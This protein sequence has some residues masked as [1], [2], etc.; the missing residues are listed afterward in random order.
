MTNMRHKSPDARRGRRQRYINAIEPF[1]TKYGC[2]AAEVFGVI[3]GIESKAVQLSYKVE[4]LNNENGKLQT[5]LTA[6]NNERIAH[7]AEMKL[8]KDQ[9][10]SQSQMISDLTEHNNQLTDENTQLTQQL[11]FTK[12]ELATSLASEV[13]PTPA[14]KSKKS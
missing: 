11:A 3:S 5:E 12:G 14:K 8:L 2:T 4:H 1:R 6:A 9:K 13:P 7:L 10:E